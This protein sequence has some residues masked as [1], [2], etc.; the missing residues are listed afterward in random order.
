MSVLRKEILVIDDDS[1]IRSVL[2]KIL[3]AAGMVVSEAATVAQAM[4][5]MKT[6]A[7][8]LVLLDLALEG[9]ELG[10]EFLEQCRKETA[11]KDVPIIILSATKNR[12]LIYRALTLGASDYM[13]KPLNTALILQKIR[14]VIALDSGFAKVTFA[15]DR[16]PKVTMVIPSRIVSISEDGFLVEAPLRIE[17]AQD[18]KARPV[19]DDIT[20][21]APLIDEMGSTKLVFRPSLNRARPSVEAP[22]QYL[23]P[24][25]YYGLTDNISNRIRRVMKRLS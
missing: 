21:R 1:D 10:T 18:D 11:F 4:A 9:D 20:I 2:R 12:A 8:H 22:G 23:A 13:A 16:Q 24:F 6:R 15:P 5:C 14:K 25:S 7:P 19:K 17:D 3:E